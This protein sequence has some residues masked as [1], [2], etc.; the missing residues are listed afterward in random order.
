[1]KTIL[2]TG[3][4]GFTG[5]FIKDIFQDK[6]YRVV[7]LSLHSSRQGEYS[8]DLTD[9]SSIRPIIREIKPSGVIHLAALSF[10]AHKKP[11]EFYTVNV[12][13]TQNL[14]EVLDEENITPDKILIASSAN[15]YGNPESENVTE[16][17]EPNPVN[18]YAQS[19]LD[20]EKMVKKWF[21][22]YKII[23]T[24]PFNY[25][26]P[27]QD[28]K[29]LVSKIVDHYR[30][31]EPVI[32]LGNI[33]IHR[34]FSDV[35]DIARAYLILFESSVKSEIINLSSGEVFSIK[36]IIN[37]MDKIAGYKIKVKINQNF[38]RKNDIRILN[39]SNT[40]LKTLTGFTP[41]YTLETTLR[42]MYA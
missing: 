7:G 34:N 26:G 32:E 42:D 28:K 25:T 14:L 2:V 4:N 22:R 36:D 35:R 24:R 10:V 1:M 5:K 12:L 17:A 29:F 37:M 9:K 13:G 18:Q 39:G 33:D 40:K 19:K 30:R 20:M 15:V 8:C 11:D 38:V 21:G 41:E 3:S 6:G 23:I 31:N 16:E 27:G